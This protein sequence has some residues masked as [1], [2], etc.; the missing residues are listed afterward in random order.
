MRK[1]EEEAVEGLKVLTKYFAAQGKPISIYYA[2]THVAKS[3][4]TR[5]VRFF[6]VDN[7]EIV[8]ITSRLAQVVGSWDSKMQAIRV[9]GCG[10]DPA[11]HVIEA[12]RLTKAR[13]SSGLMA[14]PWGEI[15]LQR[16]L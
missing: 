13:Y 12:A 16:L 10:F 2:I 15:R 6:V 5:Y 7:N 14:E 1:S 8:E 9:P 3:G 11:D 4:M